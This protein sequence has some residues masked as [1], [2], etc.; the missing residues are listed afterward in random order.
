MYSGLPNT[1]PQ[2]WDRIIFSA[3]ALNLNA[4]TI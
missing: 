4:A 3:K 2:T 1:N